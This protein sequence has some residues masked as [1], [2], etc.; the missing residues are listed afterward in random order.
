MRKIRLIPSCMDVTGY[1]PM[2]RIFKVI[3]TTLTIMLTACGGGSSGS[4]P[5]DDAPSGN[6]TETV[7]VDLSDP[8]CTGLIRAS[9]EL[10]GQPDDRFTIE[11]SA[12]GSF[13][14]ENLLWSG[15]E[16]AISFQYGPNVNG[17]RAEYTSGGP[18]IGVPA[19]ET[20]YTTPTTPT[21]PTT[22]TTTTT[23]TIPDPIIVANDP[24]C[25]EA[26]AAAIEALGAPSDQTIQFASETPNGTTQFLLFYREDNITVV[27]EQIP[28]ENICR[29]IMLPG[30]S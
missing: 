1:L 17:C 2:N 26:F 11:G 27:L 25:T 20:E 9:L 14:S 16:T 13:D 15:I 18:A 7:V 5:L 19:I 8:L 24:N 30:V 23:T 6:D 12:L 28:T 10:Y 22:T 3:S 29:I 21:T 4:A